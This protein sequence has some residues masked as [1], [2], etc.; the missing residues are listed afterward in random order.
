MVSVGVSAVQPMDL[1]FVPSG[2]KI[3]G[4]HYRDVL[5]IQNLLPNVRHFSYF[6]SFQ[7]DA[8]PAHRTRETVEIL[9]TRHLDSR[10]DN[11]E[12]R[13]AYCIVGIPHNTAI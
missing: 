11:Q 8:A 13:A 4:Q 7:Q 3:N 5:H 2:V 1:Y 9:W 10:T 12:L 6:Y